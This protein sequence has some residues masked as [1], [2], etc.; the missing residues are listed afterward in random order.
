VTAAPAGKDSRMRFPGVRAPK[1]LLSPEA[2]RQL[3]ARQLE[4]L[5][6]LEQMLLGDGL[7][8]FTMAEIA[9]LVGCS[10]RTL[11]G[12]APSKDE[13][14]LTIVDR[15]L[16]RIGRAAIEALDPSMS[17][18]DALRT[19]LQAANEAVQPETVAMSADL[20]RVNGTGRLVSSHEGYLVAVTQS[21]LDRAV[22]EG[23]IAPVDTASVAFV[24]G[25]L[26]GEF[27]RPDVA[28]IAHAPPKE[29]A[30]AISELIL[31]GLLA[32]R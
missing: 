13:L 25:R 12:I 7:A 17:P 11:Y 32:E 19:Y 14:L 3:S 5:D 27:A 6:E 26:G 28:E 8:D 31:Q 30:D 24:L 16:H 18:L 2:E 20:A 1:P 23:Q 4:V 29:T 10:L 15:R 21:L 9:A 22:S